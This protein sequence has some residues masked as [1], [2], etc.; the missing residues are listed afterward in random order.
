MRLRLQLPPWQRTAF[1]ILNVVPPGLGAFLAG[2][3]NPHTRLLR[4][5]IL[6]FALVVFG[7]WPLILPGAVGFVWAVWDAA[8]IAQARLVPLPPAASERA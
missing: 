1:A 5:G 4:N 6:Q 2:W 7:A 8:R 3:K